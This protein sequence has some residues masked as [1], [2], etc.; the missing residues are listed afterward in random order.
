MNPFFNYSVIE[1]SILD[2]KYPDPTIVLLKKCAIVRTTVEITSTL[3]LTIYILE[4][5]FRIILEPYRYFKIKEKCWHIICS[6]G[7]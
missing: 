4:K 2:R 1:P 6:T 5:I 7:S 3:F